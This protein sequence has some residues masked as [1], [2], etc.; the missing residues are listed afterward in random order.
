M[1]GQSS[2]KRDRVPPLGRPERA[3]D[4]V[5]VLLENGAIWNQLDSNDE[6]PGCVAYRLDLHVLTGPIE[7][8]SWDLLKL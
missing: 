6:T 1:S 4:V 2:S 5:N 7:H 8:D 3:L